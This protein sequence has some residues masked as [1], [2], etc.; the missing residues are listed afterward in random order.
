LR[1]LDVA[2]TRGGSSVAAPP[3][4]VNI[5]NVDPSV[6]YG[7]Q[8]LK[9]TFAQDYWGTRNYLAQTQLCSQPKAP[10]NECHWKNAAWQKIVN[11]AFRT[12]NDTKRNEL[13]AEAEKIE[14]DSGGFLVWQFNTLLDGYS[15]KLGGVIP[16]TW[17]QSACKNRYNLMYF[18]S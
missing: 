12:V 10:Y 3:H 4:R 14:Y 1:G 16:D 15:N 17:G 2:S 13:V 11:E 8:Y 5:N 6:M 18:K 9:W 7:N